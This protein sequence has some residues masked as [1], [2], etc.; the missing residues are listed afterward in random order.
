MIRRW[1]P[2]ARPQAKHIPA[3]GSSFDTSTAA[4]RSRDFSA[5]RPEFE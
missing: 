3:D 1:N 2:I 4:G 5:N